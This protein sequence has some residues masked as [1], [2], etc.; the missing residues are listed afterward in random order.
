MRFNEYPD[1]KWFG[2][3]ILLTTFL[4]KFYFAPNDYLGLATFGI[5]LAGL[6]FLIVW[7]YTSLPDADVYWNKQSGIIAIFRF[8]S[9]E[10]TSARILASVPIGIDL[11]HSGRKVLQSMYTRFL[12]ESGAELIFFINR[13]LGNESTKIGYLI[14]RRAFRLWNGFKTIERLSKKLSTDIAIL[15]R[16]MRA[17]Y[18]HL[19]VEVANLQDIVKVTTGGLETHA[20]I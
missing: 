8:W 7:S 16:S 6:I 1:P 14:R 3:A 13:P 15:E 2:L 17:A 18:P 9:V 4:F 10:I 5:G 11:S 12:N 20:L 19:P